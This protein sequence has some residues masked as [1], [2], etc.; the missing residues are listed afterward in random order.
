[1]PILWRRLFHLSIISH[2]RRGDLSMIN[3]LRPTLLPIFVALVFSMVFSSNGSAEWKKIAEG[4]RGD[5]FYLD[6]NTIKKHG[7]HIYF[8]FLQNE[9]KPDRFGHLSNKHYFKVNCGSMGAVMLTGYYY[10]KNMGRGDH[11]SK[12]YPD[13][14]WR[15]PPPSTPIHTMMKLACRR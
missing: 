12:S 4:R 2:C 3:R 1:M 6:F 8:W 5:S 13:N 15:Y 11:K 14:D 10:S 9:S 7:R